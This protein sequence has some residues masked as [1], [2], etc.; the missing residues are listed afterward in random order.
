MRAENWHKKS[1]HGYPQLSL[2][3]P[4]RSPWNFHLIWGVRCQ[5]E[6]WRMGERTESQA[7]LFWVFG[8]CFTVFVLACCLLLVIYNMRPLLLVG[9]CQFRTP[10]IRR[11]WGT[12]RW[13]CLALFVSV[14]TR[15]NWSFFDLG[16]PQL[17]LPS[18]EAQIEI[19]TT[20]ESVLNMFWVTFWSV[21]IHTYIYNIGGHRCLSTY[22]HA[23]LHHVFSTLRVAGVQEDL[24]MEWL[25]MRSFWLL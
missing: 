23:R 8:A 1:E 6:E 22:T 19:L 20:A 14:N 12:S 2:E 17:A 16:G 10:Y 7:T 3:S 11:R 18:S 5:C 21:D 13:I 15:T 25:R 4:S 9:C 24:S